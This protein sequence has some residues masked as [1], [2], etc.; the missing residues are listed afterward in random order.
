MGSFEQLGRGA[1]LFELRLRCKL[2]AC[3]IAHEDAL[4]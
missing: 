4:M 1:A 2:Q 3:V